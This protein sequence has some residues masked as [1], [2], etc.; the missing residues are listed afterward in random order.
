[1]SVSK[2]TQEQRRGAAAD[3]SDPQPWLNPEDARG[4]RVTARGSGVPGPPPLIRI[5]ALLDSEQSEWLRQESARTGLGYV[6]LV[7]RLIDDKRA[8]ATA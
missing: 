5:T 1:M 3:T 8:A 2:A 4:W 6:E 7:R